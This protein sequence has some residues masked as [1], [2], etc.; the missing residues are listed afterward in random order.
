MSDNKDREIIRPKSAKKSDPFA[1]CKWALGDWEARFY[2]HTAA[3]IESREETI[4]QMRNNPAWFK[5]K[6]RKID[7]RQAIKNNKAKG[8]RKR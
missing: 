3:H 7:P 1:Y 5:C 6:G 2:A 4:N 8:S